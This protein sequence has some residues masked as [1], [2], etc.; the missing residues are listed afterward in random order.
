M[1]IGRFKKSDA[2]KARRADME[3]ILKNIEDLQFFHIKQPYLNKL[4]LLIHILI[5]KKQ[6]LNFISIFLKLANERI[7]KA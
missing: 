6:Y 4:Y 7:D 2:I 5:I 1:Q 3:K